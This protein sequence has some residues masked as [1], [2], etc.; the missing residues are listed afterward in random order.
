MFKKFYYLT[1]FLSSLF[2]FVFFGCDNTEEKI[3]EIKKDDYN[4]VYEAVFLNRSEIL[5]IFNQMRS[6]MPFEKISNEFFIST[7]FMPDNIHSNLYG[8]KVKIHI[9]KYKIGTT[10][11]DSGYPTHNEGFKVHLESKD[12]ELQTLLD[13]YNKNYHITG[14]Y[15]DGEKYS[16]SIDFSDGKPVDIY[17]N[18]VFGLGTSDNTLFLKKI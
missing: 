12:E 13:S 1:L 5:A 11:N 4:Y 18:G 17:V 8:K 2:I 14:S 7:E 6:E 3:S 10:L 9:T 16:E 15:Q